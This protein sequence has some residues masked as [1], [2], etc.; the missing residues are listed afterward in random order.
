[1]PQL[2]NE[3]K[4]NFQIKEAIFISA[5]PTTFSDYARDTAEKKNYIYKLYPS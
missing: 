3:K 2:R 1:M 4:K 5:L